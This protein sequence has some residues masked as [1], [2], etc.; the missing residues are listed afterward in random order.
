MSYADPPEGSLVLGLSIWTSLNSYVEGAEIG[1]SCYS[2]LT[3]FLNIYFLLI[4]HK[5]LF[6]FILV[7][8]SVLKNQTNLPVTDSAS[9]HRE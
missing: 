3:F 5:H 8:I 9:P 6:F 2:S 4:C 7:Y 1:T